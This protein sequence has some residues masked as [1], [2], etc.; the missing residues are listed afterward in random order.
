MGISHPIDQP[1]RASSRETHRPRPIPF[2]RGSNPASCRRW[3]FCVCARAT[4]PTRERT[5]PTLWNVMTLPGLRKPCGDA[6]RPGGLCYSASHAASPFTRQGC[7]PWVSRSFG[8]V[9]ER[10]PP[11]GFVRLP[12]HAGPSPK[13]S[14]ARPGGVWAPAVTPRFS[15]AQKCWSVLRLVRQADTDATSRSAN[16]TQQQRRSDNPHVL[17]GLA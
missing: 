14:C 6:S 5:Y 9:Q 10:I 4:T 13:R 12:L 15:P 17:L 3:S 16:L 8:P 7:G 1:S 2:R 11:V